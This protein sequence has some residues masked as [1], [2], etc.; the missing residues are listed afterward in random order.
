MGLG[1]RRVR[2]S[3]C[4]CAFLLTVGEGMCATLVWEA[5]DPCPTADVLEQRLAESLGGPLDRA[6][7]VVLEVVVEPLADGRGYRAAVRMSAGE[8]DAPQKRVLEADSCP[9]L[10][11]ATLIVM[12][13][14]LT[15]TDTSSPPTVSEPTPAKTPPR[16]R[17]PGHE[18]EPTEEKARAE[19]AISR[20]GSPLSPQVAWALE[21]GASMDFGALPE[22]ALGIE[23]GGALSVGRNRLRITGFAFPEQRGTV[24]GSAGGVFS[25][26]GGSFAGCRS[27]ELRAIGVHACGGLELGRLQGQGTGVSRPREGG[28][29]WL[30]PRVDLT[31]TAGSPD[32][33]VF[34]RGG[35]LVPLLRPRFIL[36]DVAVHQADALAFR[37]GIGI[38]LGL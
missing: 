22:R 33:R 5:P 9:E 16:T 20:H 25:L 14:A 12:T 31:L 23:I 8:A 29:A 2:A 7:P 19:V 15:S 3:S 11:E 34:A 6:A 17:A 10:A 13:L 18:P 24:E 38:E 37:A 4:C 30:A 35:A 27:S 21:A 36:G 32:L 28:A 26:L 1:L